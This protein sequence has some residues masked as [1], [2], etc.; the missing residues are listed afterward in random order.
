MLH[1]S[2]LQAGLKLL[3]WTGAT[4]VVAPLAGIFSERFGSRPFMFAGSNAAGGCAGVVCLDG[5]HD[6]ALTLDMIV[7][8]V[9]AGAGMAL[10]F[11]VFA[12]AVLA[13]VRT[14]QAGQASGANNAIRE[15][16]GVFGVAVL[17]SVFTGA[18]GYTS[19]QAFVNG[20]IPA[21]WVGVA[22][23]AAGAFVVLVLPFQTQ[24]ATDAAVP[25]DVAVAAEVGI[26]ASGEG[27]IAAEGRRGVLA[28]RPRERSPQSS[29]ARPWGSSWRRRSRR[30]P[31]PIPR[32]SPPCAGG[33]RLPSV[34][35][36]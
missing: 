16:G 18:G 2:P 32:A 5:L 6:P 24:T 35:R 19:P 29:G 33:S 26:V 12:N 28:G 34:A 14:E 27:S 23:L 11:S 8:F 22:V 15:V 31:W 7:P 4:M 20:L 10:V 3:V 13:S 30:C 36:S 17:A 25:A 9:M 1:H 21:L